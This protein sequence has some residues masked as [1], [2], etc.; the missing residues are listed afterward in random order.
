MPKHEDLKVC[1]CRSSTCFS[2]FKC[3]AMFWVHVCNWVKGKGIRVND[4]RVILKC[5][6]FNGILDSNSFFLS[7]F[8]L[9]DKEPGAEYNE[10][11][12]FCHASLILN[13]FFTTYL[14]L[15]SPPFQW[16]MVF[17]KRWPVSWNIVWGKGGLS[18]NLWRGIMWFLLVLLS[19][20]LLTTNRGRA[21]PWLLFL[22]IVMVTKY[23]PFLWW[24]TTFEK[25]SNQPVS[26]DSPPPP[27]LM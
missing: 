11:H 14:Y 16:H 7:L 13:I 15:P 19:G 18:R 26:S 27:P 3:T 2:F 25:T 12:K 4:S 17:T 22:L 9:S 21:M 24:S 8:C 23:S 6:L 20:G 5:I 1:T 10:W